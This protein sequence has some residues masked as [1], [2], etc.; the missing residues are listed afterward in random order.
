MNFLAAVYPRIIGIYWNIASPIAFNIIYAPSVSPY[1]PNEE[2]R[3]IKI[4]I[5]P[6]ESSLVPKYIEEVI[7][8]GHRY[9]DRSTFI[10]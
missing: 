3:N 5:T 2:Y 8:L 9:I 7:D 10:Q 4:A 6:G 1:K